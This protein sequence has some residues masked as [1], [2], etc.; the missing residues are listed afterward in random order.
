MTAI[1]RGRPADHERLRTIQQITLEHPWP[2]LLETALEGPPPIYVIT[3]DHPV[4]YVIAIPGRTVYVPE[5]AVHPDHQR[6]GHGTRLLEYLADTYRDRD[7]LRVTVQAENE[8]ARRFYRQNGFAT[9]D[10]LGEY[11]DG[12]DGLLLSRDIR[13]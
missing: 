5:L 1:R 9:V 2:A 12:D 4:G 13:E 3:D 7:E 6:R 11:Y 8:P 10:R